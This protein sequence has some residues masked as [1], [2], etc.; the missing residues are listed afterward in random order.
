MTLSLPVAW[1]VS[2]VNALPPS[3]LERKRKR[4]L[5]TSLRLASTRAKFYRRNFPRP[6]RR[7]PNA[8]A[9][10][11]GEFF[12]TA[13]DLLNVPSGDFLCSSPQ[14]AFETAGTSGRNK[15][16]FYN[17]E[18]F[19]NAARRA[20][21][22]LYLCGVR[23]ED[24]ILNA[25]DFSFWFP[26]YFLARVLPYTGAFSVTVGKIEPLEVYC[27]MESYGFTVM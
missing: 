16:L 17:Y 26:G 10:G 15:R 4:A 20:S 1:A 25:Y 27:R 9:C 13:N 2:V 21:I 18:E 8:I 19:E 23:Q 22:A 6:H 5:K 24:R 12:T 14:L 3:W 7:R 11:S